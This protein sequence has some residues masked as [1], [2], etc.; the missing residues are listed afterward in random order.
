MSGPSHPDEPVATPAEL[1]D[2]LGCTVDLDL[3][4]RALTHRSFAYEA[5]GLPTNERMEFLG[6]TVLGLVVTE[7]LY[8][9]FPDLPEGR[10]AKLRASVVST[11]A[12]AEVARTLGLG[13]WLRLG[14]GEDTTGGR[15]KSSILADAVEAIL[16]AV[17]LDGGLPAAQ[18]LVLRLFGPVLDDATE[19][20]AG[21]DWKTTLQEMTAERGLGVPV[22]DVVDEGPDHAKTFSASVLLADDPSG[23]GSGRTKKEA[24]QAAAEAAVLTLSGGA[25]DERG[26]EPADGG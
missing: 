1:A 6:D 25:R 10:L 19:R 17:Y 22:Y 14:R 7:A 21:L 4:E 24:E 15:D 9:R 13:R 23:S 5:G 18:D 26:D 12:L 16:G 3:L 2:E 8:R 11:R 20:G